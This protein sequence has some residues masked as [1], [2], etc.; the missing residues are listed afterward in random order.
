M[1]KFMILYNAPEKADEFMAQ[2]T[3]EEMKAGMEAWIKWK[4]ALDD[5]VKFDFGLPLQAVGNITKT[6]V[7]DSHSSASGYSTIEG[8]SKAQIVE[9]FKTHP[10]LDRPGTSI[11]VLEMLPMPGM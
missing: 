8:D 1:P 5:S 7:G 10:H 2:S 4:D 9:L 6:V 3:P 11:D